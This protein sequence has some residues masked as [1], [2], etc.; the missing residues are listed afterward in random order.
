VLNACSAAHQAQ[1][2]GKP[3]DDRTAEVIVEQQAQ[4]Q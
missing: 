4:Q 3:E 1:A 2:S